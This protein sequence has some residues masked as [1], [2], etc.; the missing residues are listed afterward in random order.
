MI[1]MLTA[2]CA[3]LEKELFREK[4]LAAAARRA[5]ATAAPAA[6]CGFAAAV[7]ASEP[8]VSGTDFSSLLALLVQKCKY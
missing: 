4:E 8:A 5:A 3:A 7:A 1:A 2:K 6:A